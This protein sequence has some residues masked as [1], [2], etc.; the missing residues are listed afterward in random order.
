MNNNELLN[1]EHIAHVENEIGE[2]PIWVEDEQALYWVDTEASTIFKYESETD[3]LEKIK[4]DMPVAALARR[5]K[6]SWLLIAKD[7]LAVWDKKS[8]KCEFIINPESNSAIKF[9]DGCID[10]QGRLVAGTFNPGSLES[11]DGSIYRLDED[12]SIHKLDTGLTVPNGIAFSLDGK[13]LYVT[14]MFKKRILSYDYDIKTGNVS[15]KRTF[16]EIPDGKGKPDGLIIDS[17]GNLWSAHWDGSRIT[18]YDKEGRILQEISMP[19][20]KVICLAF[21]GKNLDELYVTTGWFGMSK[22]ERK[23]NPK[24]G[25]LFRIKTDEKGLLETKYKG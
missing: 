15:N 2:S 25:D 24:S 14:E 20:E 13:T 11:P 22:D 17:M 9:N 21:G 19:V 6:N 16:A 1:I 3:K 23:K 7:G 10:R 12:K 5:D 8:N 18:K 4:I